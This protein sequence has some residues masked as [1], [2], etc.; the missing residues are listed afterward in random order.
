ME[1]NTDL[2]VDSAHYAR[3]DPR[4]LVWHCS[5]QALHPGSD[6]RPALYTYRYIG[7]RRLAA[8]VGRPACQH[9][10]EC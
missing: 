4:V 3:A 7:Q 6:G 2:V 5:A 10:T 8:H 9:D 1:S